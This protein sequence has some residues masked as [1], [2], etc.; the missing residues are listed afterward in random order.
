VA[1]A[2]PQASAHLSIMTV[3]AA[4]VGNPVEKTSDGPT[5]GAFPNEASASAPEVTAA[6]PIAP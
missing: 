6:A 1:L 4:E 2:S 5:I 3:A